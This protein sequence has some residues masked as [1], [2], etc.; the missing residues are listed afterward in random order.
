M[1]GAQ[2]LI[3]TR[4]ESKRSFLKIIET[5]QIKRSFL[6]SV[7]HRLILIFGFLIIWTPT[8]GDVLSLSC[9]RNKDCLLVLFLVLSM[10]PFPFYLV[11]SLIFNVIYAKSNSSPQN[12]LVLLKHIFKDRLF[13]E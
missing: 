2:T 13:C 3:G 9:P 10:A 7:L 5:R 11:Y 8:G 1:R 4:L 12:L 6:N